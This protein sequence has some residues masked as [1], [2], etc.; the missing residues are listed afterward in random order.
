MAKTGFICGVALLSL[1][2]TALA[3][4]VTYSGKLGSTDIVVEFTADPA[5]ADKSL[6]GRYFYRG[7]G[8]DIPL[9]PGNTKSGKAIVLNE[10]EV[11]R[12]DKCGEGQAAP[13]GATWSLSASSDG[14]TLTGT[15]K[16]KKS[17]PL[18]LERVAS[19]PQPAD[20]D[21]TSLGL[22]RFSDETFYEDH[23]VT[24]EASPYDY[25]RL[26]YPVNDGAEQGWPDARWRFVTDPRTKFDRPRV[27]AVEGGSVDAVNETLQKDHWVESLSALSCAALQYSGFHDGPPVDS[28]DDG[29]L[30]GWDD[31][32]ASVTFLSPKL[33][34][35]TEGGSVWCGGAHPSNFTTFTNIDI[36]S[37]KKLSLEDIFTDVVEGKPGQSLVSFVRLKREKPTE[38]TEID[39]QNECGIDDLIAEYLDVRFQRDGD[40]E[41]VIFGLT[42]LPH[43]I[44]ACGDDVLSMPVSDAKSL[45]KPEFAA[46]LAH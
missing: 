34:S 29:T 3:D 25:L 11:C 32:S 35:W 45:F 17:L 40:E 4:P 6:G 38:Q 33:L 5:K 30:G 42:G 46:L 39:Y 18:R 26:E 36:A 22:Y 9:Q 23:Y 13:I 12:A 21:P 19:R 14:K 15:W 20:Y 16:A 27:V 7:K 24:K 44:N 1:A 37:G 10:E 28:T 2:T 41:T 31:T 8:I 43:V